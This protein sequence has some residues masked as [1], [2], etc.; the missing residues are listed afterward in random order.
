MCVCACVVVVALVITR[1][2]RSVIELANLFSLPAAVAVAACAAAAA[3][4]AVAASSFFFLSCDILWHGHCTHF[5][6]ALLS[7]L[8]AL[9]PSL[10]FSFF[11]L[12]P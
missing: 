7:H 11:S 3:A 5:L 2:S 4:F 12:F 9:L 10:Y 1:L 8:C 6:P